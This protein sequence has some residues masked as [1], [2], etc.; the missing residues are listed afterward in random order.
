MNGQLGTLLWLMYENEELY[1][2]TLQMDGFPDPF[3]TLAFPPTFGL[4]KYDEV[5]S[6]MDWKD[7]QEVAGNKSVNF[8]D[9]GYVVSVHRSQG[10]EFDK[11]I[12]LEERSYYW[13][14]EYY[15]KWLYTGVTRAKEK[16]FVV[17]FE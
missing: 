13:D 2:I 5:F 16:L 12:L 8:F 11:V 9:Y 7:L 6:N 17:G 4:E 14:D 10:S 3:Q 15:K 1:D